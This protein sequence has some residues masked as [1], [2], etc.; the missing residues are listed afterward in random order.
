MGLNISVGI[1][2]L[3]IPITGPVYGVKCQHRNSGFKK[4][5]K[6][7]V[8]GIKHQCRNSG[9]RGQGQYMGL[10]INAVARTSRNLHQEQ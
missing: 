5:T 1:Q 6:G 8:D 4:F 3:G 2:V 7:P 10:N 9:L